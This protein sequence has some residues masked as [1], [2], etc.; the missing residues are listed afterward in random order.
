MNTQASE[1]RPVVLAIHA[2]GHTFAQTCQ[3]K[4]AETSREHATSTTTGSHHRVTIPE[5]GALFKHP[6]SHKSQV[7]IMA[8]SSDYG[9]D[10]AEKLMRFSYQTVIHAVRNNL[11]C[12]L[13][14]LLRQAESRE[15]VAALG[16][17]RSLP[18]G[19]EHRQQQC[20]E[21]RCYGDHDQESDQ[22]KA[23]WQ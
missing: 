22:R 7:A 12:S 5:F 10:L 2:V 17:S 23:Q 4:H 21:N 6:L 19:V 20:Y 11:P 9:I 8:Y 13:F 16:S 1:K 3:A 15:A 14:V 18:G